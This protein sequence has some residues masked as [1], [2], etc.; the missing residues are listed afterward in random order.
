MRH[1]LSGLG[2]G[3]L[4]VLAAASAGAQNSRSPLDAPTTLRLPAT[5][6][7]CGIDT[8]VAKL[9]ETSQVATGF[10]GSQDCWARFPRIDVTYDDSGLTKMTVRQ[11]LDQ[12]GVRGST[13]H[14]R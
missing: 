10:E 5:L 12:L 1:R 4:V 3:V 7:R 13:G 14:F 2:A 8:A 11:A 6:P 9:P